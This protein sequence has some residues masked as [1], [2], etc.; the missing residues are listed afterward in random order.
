MTGNG[1]FERGTKARHQMVGKTLHET[2][3]IG[4]H[5]CVAACQIPTFNACSQC[6]KEFVRG[7]RT[8]PRQCIEEARFA[9]IGVANQR[10]GVVLV[11]A[12][13]HFA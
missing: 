3:G 7:I 9:G 12:L 2:N 13:L 11:A 1:I 4:E 6:C 10:S 5:G 8:A